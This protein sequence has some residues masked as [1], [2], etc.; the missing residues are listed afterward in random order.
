MSVHDPLRTFFD[1][2]QKHQPRDGFHWWIAKRRILSNEPEQGRLEI[3]RTHTA[4]PGIGK[5][6]ESTH[7]KVRAFDWTRSARNIRASGT[8]AASTG[9]TMT[10]P[11]QC[12]SYVRKFLSK[13]RPHVT[14]SGHRAERLRPRSIKMHANFLYAG[15]V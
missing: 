2:N 4:V 9:R 5:T 13:R 11:D 8:S 15:T 1:L 10:A 12:C 3:K 7:F 6:F 14:Q